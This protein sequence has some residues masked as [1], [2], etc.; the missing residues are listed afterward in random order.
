MSKASEN[1]NVNEAPFYPYV[2]VLRILGAMAVV[3]AHYGRFR[4]PV[5]KFAVPCFVV[6]SF[7]FGWRTIAAG[8]FARLRRC[9][10][11]LAV[12]FF[13]W[14]VVSYVV[15]IAQG[16]K[17]GI[18]PLLW[19]M[20][21]GH[22]TCMPLYYLWDVAAMTVFLFVLG[23][24]L[25]GRAFWWAAGGIVLACFALQVSG[26]NYRLFSRLPFEAA[27]PLGRLAELLPSA[28][29]GCAIAAAATRGCGTLAV[30]LMAACVP[31][32]LLLCGISGAKDGFGYAGPLL[33]AGASGMVL[34]ATAFTSGD[35]RLAK[36][37]LLS[38]ATAGVYFIHT[39]VGDVLHVFKTP[40][41]PQVL[42]ISLLVTLI[43][44][45][46]PIV[47]VLFNGKVRKR[48]VGLA[49]G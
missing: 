9:L 34:A 8:D 38:E 14:G 22:S 43:G 15:A 6:I 48:P 28:V 26:L 27:F 45:R 47:R 5:V 42:L 35:P 36:I 37:R 16:T 17:S 10:F 4:I 19:Q 12:P 1:E 40:K 39:I 3:W 30:G 2:E 32:V 41:F 13:A 44:L 23:R 18:S 31:V 25:S 21:L 33:L 20:L 49:S 46:L 29:A 7:F 24:Y 11:R